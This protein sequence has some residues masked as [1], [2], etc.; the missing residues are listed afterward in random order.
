MNQEG[1]CLHCGY[2]NKEKY[3]P[4]RSDVFLLKGIRAYDINETG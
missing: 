3:M 2:Q 1:V 4:I